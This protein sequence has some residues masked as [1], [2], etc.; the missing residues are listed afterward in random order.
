V[1]ALA[2]SSTLVPLFGLTAVCVMLSGLAALG[3]LGLLAAGR[4]G[5]RG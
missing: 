4:G 2:V 3:L 1:G 5:N